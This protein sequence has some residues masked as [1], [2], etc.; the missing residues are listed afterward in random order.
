M[1][2]VLSNECHKFILSS[3]TI[4]IGFVIILNKYVRKPQI[5]FESNYFIKIIVVQLKEKK[6]QKKIGLLK[7]NIDQYVI[8]PLR[9]FRV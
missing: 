3:V 9:V 8:L 2:R 7:P 6:S 5:A 1:F 4:N